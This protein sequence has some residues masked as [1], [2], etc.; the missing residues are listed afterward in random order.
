VPPFETTASEE[1][2]DARWRPD[3]DACLYT[4]TGKMHRRGVFLGVDFL[5]GSDRVRNPATGG[6]TN[7]FD[8]D[9]YH[10]FGTPDWTD[11]G[12][13]T[14]ADG[15]LV[16]AGESLRFG[17]WHDNG[18]RVPVRLGCEETVGEPPGTIAAGPAK[19]CTIIGRNPTE[20]PAADPAYPG[21]TFTGTCSAA[22]LVAGSDPNDEVCALAGF[23]YDALPGAAACDP[24][25]ATAAE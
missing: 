10:L 22:N 11:A 15:F 17:C 24:S 6:A 1:R 5:D 18:T 4:V 25:A 16:R 2:V 19:P 9:R 21:R 3:A 8:L 13:R 7:P 23:Y 20:C 12:A 14:F